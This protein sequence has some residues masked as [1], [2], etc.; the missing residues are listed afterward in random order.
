MF[1]KAFNLLI[2]DVE[3][4]EMKLGI[5]VF[6]LSVVFLGVFW[7]GLLSVGFAHDHKQTAFA[8]HK[9]LQVSML[10]GSQA[11]FEDVFIELAPDTYDYSITLRAS[12]EYPRLRR[13]EVVGVKGSRRL[14]Y[15]ETMIEERYDE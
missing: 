14:K 3:G 15:D 12:H 10:D 9:A 11:I 2:V 5:K 4:D 6:A 7:I 1:R 13:I 8:Y